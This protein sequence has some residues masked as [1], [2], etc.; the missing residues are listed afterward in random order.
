MSNP[1]DKPISYVLELASFFN[2]TEYANLQ[3]E[4]RKIL[5]DSYLLGIDRESDLQILLQDNKV[6]NQACSCIASR[7]ICYDDAVK[8]DAVKKENHVN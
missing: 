6:F 3:K 2:P 4:I 7:Y 1:T 5:Q 8:K